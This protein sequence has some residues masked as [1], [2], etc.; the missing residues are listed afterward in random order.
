[1]KNS[2]KGSIIVIS[3][4]AGIT[5]AQARSLHPLSYSIRAQMLQSR[6]ERAIVARRR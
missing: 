4:Q 5:C 3:E 1:M 2:L 6:R